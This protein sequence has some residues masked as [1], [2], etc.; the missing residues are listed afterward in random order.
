MAIVESLWNQEEQGNSKDLEEGAC[1]ARNP[2]ADFHQRSAYR[3]TYKSR[4]QRASSNAKEDR[5]SAV[6]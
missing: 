1:Q 5:R 4:D 6:V 3:W 2:R